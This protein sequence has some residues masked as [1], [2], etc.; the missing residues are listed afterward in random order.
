MGDTITWRIELTDSIYD[1]SREMKFKIENFP[2]QP[3]FYLFK[4]EEDGWSSGYLSNRIIVDS[5]YNTRFIGQSSILPTSFR[6]YSTYTN[7]I[8]S[9]E[10]MVILDTPGVYINYVLDQIRTANPDEIKNGQY[11]EYLD[12]IN[13]SGCPDPYYTVNYTLQGEPHYEEFMEEMIFL[14]QEVYNDKWTQLGG[15][16]QDMWG[17]TGGGIVVDWRGVMGFEVVE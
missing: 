5:I 10:Y 7:G 4:M 6:G 12:I 16:I 1:L 13:H 3:F 14:D 9:Y 8:Y 17:G 11:P 15:N 2:F